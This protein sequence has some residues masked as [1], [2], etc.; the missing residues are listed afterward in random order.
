MHGTYLS[1][2]ERGVNAPTWEKLRDLAR[3][4]EVRTSYLLAQAEQEARRRAEREAG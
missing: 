4:L 2:I 1:R 3:S